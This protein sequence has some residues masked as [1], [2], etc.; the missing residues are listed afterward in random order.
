MNTFKNHTVMNTFKKPEILR[1]DRFF[2]FVQNILALDK[3]GF[4]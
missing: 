1:E 3:I 2:L 4:L